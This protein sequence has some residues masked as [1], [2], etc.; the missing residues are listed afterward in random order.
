MRKLAVLAL[1][2]TF[3]ITL[4]AQQSEQKPSSD[5]SKPVLT[6]I[7]P[8]VPEAKPA[9]VASI[10]T[11]LAALYDVISGP[12]G[13]RD[14]D[15][16]NSLFIPEAHL[17]FT[18]KKPDGTPVHRALT[19]KEYEEHSGAFFL[20]EGFFENSIANKVDRFGQVAQ[21]F[22]TYESRHEKGAKPFARGIN[23]IQLMNDGK[24]W[25]VVS[26]LWDSE[27]PDNPIPQKY[28]K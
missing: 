25:W 22:S 2:L 1:T 18:G 14:W 19:P 26:I 13:A 10:D 11:I 6:D 16:F 20:K 24:R 3:A 17:I 15:R 8:D 5:A 12:P 21:V 4:L 9:D 23:S 28:L 7:K 27:R